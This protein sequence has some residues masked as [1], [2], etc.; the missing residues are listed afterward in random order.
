MYD[1]S[2]LRKGLKIEYNNAPYAIIEYLHVNPGK[3]SAFVRTKLKNLQTGQVIDITFK[4]SDK[5]GKP[6]LE[7]RDMQYLYFDGAYHFMDQKT[8]EQVEIDKE[9]I[10]DD[11]YFLV[12]EK[13]VKMLFYNGKTVSIDFSNFVALEVTETGPNIKGDT[14]SSSGKPAT[15]STGLV[16]TVPFHINEGDVL[17]IDTRT[18]KYVERVSV[19]K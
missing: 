12:E 11:K 2:E 6:D 5:V 14:A 3:G 15:L 8:F 7:E 4:A 17:K 13:D 18:G 16:V 1:A 9:I 19:G 10:G